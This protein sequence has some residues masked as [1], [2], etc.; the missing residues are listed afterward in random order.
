MFKH[1]NICEKC[2][3][4]YSSLFTEDVSSIWNFEHSVE[5][6]KAPGGTALNSVNSQITEARTFITSFSLVYEDNVERE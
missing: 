3:L 1:R 4:F 5:Q 6:Y 2:P